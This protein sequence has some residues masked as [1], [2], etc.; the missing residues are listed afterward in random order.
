MN[1]ELEG[2]AEKLHYT[3]T[4]RMQRILSRPLRERSSCSG[5]L[6]AESYQA[7]TLFFD[8]AINVTSQIST[9]FCF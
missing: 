4:I 5:K 9:R 6:T 1:L 2:D 8:C 3:I 7:F